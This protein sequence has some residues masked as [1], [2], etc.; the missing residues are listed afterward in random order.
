MNIKR[1]VL[2]S[3][4]ICIIFL[5]IEGLQHG[6]LLRSSYAEHPE[7]MRI[8]G[9][10]IM[11]LNL[12]GGI[13]FSFMFSYIFA[14]GYQG[15]GLQEGVRF[16]IIISLFLWFPKLIFEYANLNYPGSWPLIWFIFGVTATVISGIAA[17][18]I[19]R[20]VKSD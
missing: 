14:R 19:Y 7:F 15:K 17:A 1:L 6:V 4:V 13:V 10:D 20:P 2:T 9:A 11:I 16:G 5:L 8:S 18:F 3:V 12:I